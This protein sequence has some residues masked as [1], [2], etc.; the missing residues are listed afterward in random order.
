MR[1]VFVY[2][3]LLDPH[4]L[5]RLVGRVMG[6]QPAFATGWRRDRLAGTPYPTL[7]PARGTVTGG[8]I[9]LDDREVR[10]LQRYE[11]PRYRLRP[12]TAR[13]AGS[14]TDQRVLAWIARG[15]T[16]RGWP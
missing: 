13:V 6:I 1:R 4:L 2:G 5:T 15:P 9:H 8:I 16:V 12:V 11:G 10:Q 3:T 14:R 7:V